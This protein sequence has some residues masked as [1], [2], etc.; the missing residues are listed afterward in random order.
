MVEELL[1]K[2]WKI[3]VQKLTEGNFS[4]NIITKKSKN[5]SESAEIFDNLSSKNTF[6][7]LET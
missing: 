5:C 7:S 3:S 6:S 2:F 1:R 4:F